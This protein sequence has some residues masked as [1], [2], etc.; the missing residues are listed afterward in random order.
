MVL[1]IS[2]M[3]ATMIDPQPYPRVWDDI[4]SLQGIVVIDH[5]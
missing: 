1:R 3:I 5:I 4:D 2:S